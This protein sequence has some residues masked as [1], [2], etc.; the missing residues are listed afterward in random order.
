MF[1]YI[2]QFVDRSHHPK[3]DDYLFRLLR[4]RSAEAAEAAGPRWKP[5]IARARQ[6]GSQAAARQLAA[7][8][9]GELPAAALRSPRRCDATPPGSKAISGSEE[10]HVLPLARE[11]LQ[12]QDDW[13]EIDRA[14]LDNNDPLF[15]DQAQAE[16]RELFHR[17]VS[18]AP[19]SVGLGGQSAGEP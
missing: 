2:E 5:T 18:L 16:F 17:I 19:E 14:F 4:L 10:K 12:P 13:Q 1:D 6:P 3:E 8:A 11:V 7:A 15:G 9:Q